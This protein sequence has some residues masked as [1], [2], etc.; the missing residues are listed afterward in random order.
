MI[1]NH[2]QSEFCTDLMLH[3]STLVRRVTVTLNVYMA[4]FDPCS[5]G[6]PVW[7]IGLPAL[8]GHPTYHVNVIKLK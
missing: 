5:E 6:Y 3:E 7:Q 4:K 8:A 2:R 1:Q